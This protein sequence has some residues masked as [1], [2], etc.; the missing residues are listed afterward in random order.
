[1]QNLVGLDIDGN[2]VIKPLSEI[3]NLIRGLQAKDVATTQRLNTTDATIRANAAANTRLDTK[4]GAETRNRIAHVNR[5]EGQYLMGGKGG[6]CP[7]G[8]S[9]IVNQAE[10]SDYGIY[11]KKRGFYMTEELEVAAWGQFSHGCIRLA[12][13]PDYLFNT[14]Q[15]GPIDSLER[16]VCKRIVSNK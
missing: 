11:Q 15:G 14:H 1:M 6:G 4:I 2:I 5:E 7:T 3:E 13:R 16:H 8:Y 12:D 9:K 10:C